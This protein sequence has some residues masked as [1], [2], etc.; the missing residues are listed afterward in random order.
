MRPN[1]LGLFDMHGNVWELCQNLYEDFTD[2]RDRN[3]DD[4]VDSKRSRS[5]RGGSF[6]GN[7]WLLRSVIRNRSTPVNRDFII[8]FRPARTF[9]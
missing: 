9:R 8:G 2:M 6:Q 5:L 4:K 3:I 7:P 1:D